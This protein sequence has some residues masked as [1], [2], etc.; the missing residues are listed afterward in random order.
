VTSALFDGVDSGAVERLRKQWDVGTRPVVMY[1][2][3]DNTSQRVDYLLRA[4]AVIREQLPE[5][6]LMIA[7]PNGAEPNRSANEAL[8]RGLGVEC[9]TR[10]L[11][12]HTLADLKNYLALSS[13]CVVPRPENPGQPIKLLN[14]MGMSKPT[15]CFSGGVKAVQHMHDALIVPDHNWRAMGNA[16]IT[17]LRQPA[18]RER[19]GA[20]ARQTVLQD[21]D[22]CQL[23]GKIEGIYD[24]VLKRSSDASAENA[25][26]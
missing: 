9:D 16:I 17:L 22:C 14:Y 20:N 18:L 25:I 24:A 1:A 19:I 23:C 7:S 15:V 26:A 8:A 11:G 3:A 2:G 4:F 21:F 6:L 12:P 13:V 10:F 5:A